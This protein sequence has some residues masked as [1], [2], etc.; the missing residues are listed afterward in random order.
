MGTVVGVTVVTDDPL[1]AQR[2]IESAYAAIETYE[3]E[4]SEWRPTSR[5]A[6]LARGGPVRF[7]AAGDLLLNVAERL[8][9]ASGGRFDVTWRSHGRLAETDDGWICEGRSMDTG[10]LLK[11]F[12]ND[13]AAEA[14][15]AAGFMDFLIDAAGDVLAHGDAE[16]GRGWRVDV[17]GTGLHVRL[18]DEALSTSGN[19]QQP[20][21]IHSALTGAAIDDPGTVAVVA[22]FGLLADGVAT[23]IF[24]GAD[25]SLAEAFGA[26]A[27]RVEGDTVVRSTGAARRFR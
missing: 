5:M 23:A 7:S 20:G 14:L 15:V 12:L 27:V 24:T 16:G 11:G 21:H 1:A 17:A 26:V 10:G 25:V 4:L 6:A 19:Q 13:R 8:R 22:P 18:R 3:A 9:R 2:G